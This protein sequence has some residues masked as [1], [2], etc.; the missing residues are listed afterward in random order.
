MPTATWACPPSTRC[1]VAQH[2]GHGFFSCV[3]E[4]CKVTWDA[5]GAMR[6]TRPPVDG[7]RNWGGISW[8]PLRVEEGS[9]PYPFAQVLAAIDWWLNM[10]QPEPAPAMKLV[11]VAV[12]VEP[13]ELPP[14]PDEEQVAP[15]A[16]EPAETS[17]DDF[18][19]SWSLST[20]FDATTGV[21]TLAIKPKKASAN[22]QARRRPHGRV[23]EDDGE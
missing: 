2:H 6:S 8:T 21:S 12:P 15:A 17:T 10:P 7:E 23:Q 3:A 18:F 14:A 9:Y 11:E 19:D 13:V 22:G 5:G 4:G 16:E 20:A 1:G